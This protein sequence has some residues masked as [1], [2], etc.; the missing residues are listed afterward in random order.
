MNSLLTMNVGN[1]NISVG[2]WEAE[3]LVQTWRFSTDAN[4]TADEFGLM[5]HSMLLTAG[6]AVETIAGAAISSVVPP[7][8]SALLQ[9]C[10]KYLQVE[11]LLVGP[12]VKTGLPMR[13][14]N[15]RDVGSDRVVN[16]VAAVA[17]YGSP[18]II[19]KL[20]TATTLCVVDNTGSYVGG[21]IAPGIR[22]GLD[23]LARRA[24]KLP[25]VELSLPSQLIGK[26]TVQSM[27][28]GAVYGAISM[29]DGLVD[30]IQDTFA[31][32]FNVVATGGL[33]DLIG[34]ESR[35]IKH[36]HPHLTLAGL[37]LLWDRNRGV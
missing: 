23:A 11:P 9:T 21:I 32:E 37:R 27:Q 25:H 35:R 4:R 19:V 30:R 10:E 1:S 20:G 16:A 34:T 5:L 15:P 2:V 29:I 22:T 12:G 8:G 31:Y 14:D 28:S 3:Q 26:N 33:V 24:A 36:V 18:V 6:V 13:C 7:L 17:Y